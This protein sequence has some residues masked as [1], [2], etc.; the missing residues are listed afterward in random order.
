MLNDDM[1]LDFTD[2]IN[3]SSDKKS[4]NFIIGGNKTTSFEG[5][6][7]TFAKPINVKGF[8]I[9]NDKNISL[10]ASVSTELELVC[11]RCLETFIYPVNIE[12]HEEFTNNRSEEDDETNLLTSGKV[13]ITEIVIDD[14]LSSLPIKKLCSENCRG[15]CQH[16]GANLNKTKCDCNSEDIDPRLEKLKELFRD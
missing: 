2:L 14:I 5:E 11:S 9:K 12:I 8:A 13:E 16:C 7:I 6:N 10:D 1:I 3:N 15:L 4:V